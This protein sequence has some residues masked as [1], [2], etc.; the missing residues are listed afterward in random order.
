MEGILHQ[1][2]DSKS[3]VAILSL[4]LLLA[5]ESLAPYFLFFRRRL[6]ERAQHAFRN[7]VLILLN[8]MLISVLFI[9]S[10]RMA[11]DFASGRHLGLLNLLEFPG[12]VE[13][14]L[15]VLLF[16]FW[17]Y[18]WHRFNHRI[19]FLWRFHRVHHS[20]PKMDVTTSNRFHVGEIF[21]SAVLRI[22]LIVLFGAELWHLALYEALMFPI[23]QFHHANV[24]VPL[25]L[26]R[27]LRT[28]V[29]TPEMH[30]VH[31]SR[32]QPETDSNYTSMLS[33]WDRVFGS[34]RISED[35]GTISFGLDGY[36][37]EEKQTVTGM[38]GTPG[39][40]G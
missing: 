25:W 38:L 39:G 12:W 15:A 22:P 32:Y 4:L 3:A 30:K 31:H 5:W 7:F 35:A 26:D 17:T 21:I 27:G 34:F 8:A 11:S 33:I 20:D 29:V 36:D 24:G 14:L 16:D 13:A 37:S 10:W 28:V 18:W 1:I 2:G 19:P 6:K 23:V 9:A 40:K